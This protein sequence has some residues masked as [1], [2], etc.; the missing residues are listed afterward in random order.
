MTVDVDIDTLSADELF[1]LA[2]RAGLLVLE[3]VTTPDIL[4]ARLRRATY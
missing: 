1:S 2:E 3:E 4:R